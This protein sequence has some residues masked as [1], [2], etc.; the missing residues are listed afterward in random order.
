MT[1]KLPNTVREAVFEKDNEAQKFQRTSMKISDE[2]D[3]CDLLEVAITQSENRNKL[4][5]SWVV[6]HGKPWEIVEQIRT[7]LHLAT[8]ET[9]SI[10]D[11]LD[12]IGENDVATITYS[13]FNPSEI[14][15]R[16]SMYK[17]LRAIQIPII[18]SLFGVN[19]DSIYMFKAKY[20]PRE[21]LL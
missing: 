8:Y 21:D 18:S 13:V 17:E 6:L 7:K 3:M 14:I 16:S 5:E 2:A 4:I 15:Q 10:F 1:S 11:Y 12:T 9:Q 20:N 19:S